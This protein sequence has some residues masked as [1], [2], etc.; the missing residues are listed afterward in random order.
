MGLL[1]CFWRHR[2]SLS[3]V[4]LLR[5]SVSG[6]RRASSLHWPSA[7]SATSFWVTARFGRALVEAVVDI[8]AGGTWTQTPMKEET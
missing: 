1:V 6:G 2:V 5:V 3:S 4:P 8:G 7:V